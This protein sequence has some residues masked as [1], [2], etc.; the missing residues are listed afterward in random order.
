MVEW[1]ETA[2]GLFG[3]KEDCRKYMMQRRMN[4]VGTFLLCLVRNTSSKSL[5]IF[6]LEGKSF[7][8]G[9][10]LFPHNYMGLGWS[11]NRG[12]REMLYRRAAQRSPFEANALEVKVIE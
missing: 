8:G 1:T 4:R 5:C 7:P 2:H 10:S 11:R 6:V 3:W 12:M 9:W